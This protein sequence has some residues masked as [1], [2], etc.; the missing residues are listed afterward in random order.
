MH[1]DKLKSQNNY[2]KST[3]YGQKDLKKICGRIDGEGWFHKGVEWKVGV[4]DKT[5]FWHDECVEGKKLIDLF[6]RLF[7]LTNQKDEVVGK[8]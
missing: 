3:I 7:I 8:M 6:P 4:G 1:H 2:L 5:K